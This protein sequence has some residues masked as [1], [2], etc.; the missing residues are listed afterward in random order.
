V[1]KAPFVR[2]TFFDQRE[3]VGARWWHESMALAA[4]SRRNMFKSLAIIGGA[5]AVLGGGGWALWRAS[6]PPMIVGDAVDIQKARG[7]NLGD[8][9]VEIPFAQEADVGGGRGF[10]ATFDRLAHELGPHAE[11][12]RPYYVPTLFQSL[13]EPGNASLIAAMRPMRSPEMVA[14]EALGDALG[15][16]FDGLSARATAIVVD[17]PG[18]Q[19][20]S[21][22]AGAARVCDPVFL[23][24][25]WPHPLGVVPAHL[26]LAAA[27]F[28]FPRFRELSPDRKD[29]APAL[30]VLDSA[31]LA[32][33]RD[34]ANQFDNR[35][36]A[37][38]PTADNLKEL[39]VAHVLYVTERP[40]P[41][42]DDL[43]DDFVA[44]K[45]AGIDVKSVALTDFQPSEDKRLWRADT[46]YWYGGSPATHAWFWHDYGWYAPSLGARAVAPTGV[47]RGFSYAPARRATM[48]SGAGPAKSKP[49]GFGRVS[50]APVPE[51]HPAY[52]GGGGGGG[53]YSSDT[54]TGSGS[55][56]SWGRT[57][58]G[59]GSG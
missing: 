36:V 4:L 38:L 25:N 2:K 33:Y 53:T 37:K 20:V 47:S 21:F 16:L 54:S 59:G 22:A 50:V 5:A 55:G 49:R 45:D 46:A 42:L 28:W 6:A 51:G 27:V 58:G 56:G 52:A 1:S 48:F 30:F 9:T 13:G 34:D 41:E 23:F 10:A 32:P 43:N 12:L 39:G 15:S 31:R 3:L 29:D 44:F 18:A 11:R 26:A 24:D 40:G 8:G 35:W 17:L 57:Y 14:A 7:W 19:A